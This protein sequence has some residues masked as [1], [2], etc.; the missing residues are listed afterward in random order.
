MN[1]ECRPALLQII[2]VLWFSVKMAPP[3]QIF[4]A[5]D[6]VLVK[7]PHIH[8]LHEANSSAQWSQCISF[9]LSQQQHYLFGFGGQIEN[10]NDPFSIRK[11][12]DIT[13]C[14]LLLLE[15]IHVDTACELFYM[16]PASSIR[17]LSIIVPLELSNSPGTSI[18]YI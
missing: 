10:S 12:F 17:F 3:L 4:Q 5:A 9:S 16:L 1:L 6:H 14:P 15:L 2:P 11:H 7:F 8:D 13:G 18:L